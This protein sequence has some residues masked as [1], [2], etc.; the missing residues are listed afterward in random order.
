MQ[1]RF[2]GR[3]KMLK[4]KSETTEEAVDGEEFSERKE[5]VYERERTR[6]RVQ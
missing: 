3:I 5:Q 4:G 6:G 1:R 2:L